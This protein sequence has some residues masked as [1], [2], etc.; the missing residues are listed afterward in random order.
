MRNEWPSNWGAEHTALFNFFSVY[1]VAA[2][3]T[4]EI[5]KGIARIAVVPIDID[6][7]LL[8]KALPLLIDSYQM[9]VKAGYESLARDFRALLGVADR[10]D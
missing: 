2:G 1:A 8:R 9:G 4:V 3:D 6:F 7:A 5:H 10:R